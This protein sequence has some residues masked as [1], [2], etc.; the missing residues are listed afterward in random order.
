MPAQVLVVRLV[1]AGGVE[2]RM[3][4]AAAAKKATSDRAITGGFFDGK[5]KQE[6]V[7]SK[8]QGCGHTSQR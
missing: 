1:S 2:A 7:D 3:A 5:V 6:G 8:K 4:A